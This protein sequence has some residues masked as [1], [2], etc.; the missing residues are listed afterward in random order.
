[1]GV[2]DIRRRSATLGNY[3]S[4]GGITPVNYAAA[5]AIDGQ[6]ARARAAGLSGGIGGLGR[7][8]DKGIAIIAGIRQ[9]ENQRQVDNASAEVQRR[10]NA[11]MIGTGGDANGEPTGAM[12]QDFRDG[13]AW[14]DVNDKEYKRI[15]NK[16]REEQKLTDEQTELMRR[17]LNSYQTN[18]MTRQHERANAVYE[19]SLKDG[20]TSMLER[21]EADVSMGSCPEGWANWNEAMENWLKVNRVTDAAARDAFKGA[22]ALKLMNTAATRQA[23]LYAAETSSSEDADDVGRKYDAWIKAAE[24]NPDGLV[25]GVRELRDNLGDERIAKA[26][27]LFVDRLREDKRK[28]VHNAQALRERKVSQ[29]LRESYAAE[30]DMILSDQFKDMTPMQK[31]DAYRSFLKQM[32]PVLDKDG[33]QL[34]WEEAFKAYGGRGNHFVNAVKTYEKAAKAEEESAR[35]S[36]ETKALAEAKAREKA[37]AKQFEDDMV[38]A[39]KQPMAFS[40]DDSGA[41]RL[42]ANGEA[43]TEELTPQRRMDIA[44]RLWQDGRITEAGRN[45]IIA[46]NR[47]EFNDNVKTVCQ[48]VLQELKVAYPKAVAFRANANANGEGEFQF[49]A[50]GKAK[51]PEQTAKSDLHNFTGDWS[52]Y[53]DDAENVAYGDCVQAMNITMQYMA[54][55]PDAT[56]EDGKKY[57]RSILEGRDTEGKYRRM[58]MA[59][60]FADEMRKLQALESS[61]KARGRSVSLGMSPSGKPVTVDTNT[62]TK[63]D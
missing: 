57:Y 23:S 30:Q 43:I 34:T 12:N 45:E 22:R 1:M 58:K 61:F 14:M 48:E 21:R 56:V 27:A 17:S 20:A 33:T 53:R 40:T 47:T 32:S 41:V 55:H 42:D 38:L 51:K 13:P 60:H 54:K 9:K 35:K 3:G 11:Y 36:Y 19:K 16:V 39:L 62:T 28:A 37:A 4:V 49:A 29:A 7:M 10:F 6:T 8:A 44:M 63:R 59:E 18:W 2:I 15:F 52:W 46:A 24:E 31:A 25:G 50:N 5:A 26:N